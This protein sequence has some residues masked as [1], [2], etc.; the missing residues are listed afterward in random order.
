MDS[1]GSVTRMIHD[2]RSDDPGVR[3]LAARRIWQRYFRELLVLAR[4]HLSRRIRRRED[5]QD[6]LQSMYKSF[7]RRQRRGD[8][9]LAGRD[10]LWRLLVTI[11]L[12]KARNA[13]QRHLCAKRD[14]G[15]E[16]AAP[17]P[18]AG[19]DSDSS[20]WTLEQMEATEPTPAEAALLNEALELRLMQLA[21][22][23]LH[24]VAL[25]K[26][27]GYTNLEIAARFQCTEK[28]IERKLKRIRAR[29]ESDT[30][31]A[32]ERG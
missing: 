11:T 29:W 18:A 16:Q 27:E 1:P 23:E 17:P 7:C 4:S 12:R 22:A 14:V 5:E 21:D 31:S 8:F 10:E 3:E 28:T 19:G 24:Q 9:D 2:L 30:D 32:P 20:T 15:R 25:W 13:A 26:L 6:V